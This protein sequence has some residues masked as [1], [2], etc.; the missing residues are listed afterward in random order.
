[1]TRLGI[2]GSN[3]RQGGGVTH[4]SSLLACVEPER[5]G[6]ERVVLWAGRDILEL[7]PDAP[8][9][10]KSHQADLDGG[11]R[12]RLS[13]QKFRFPGMADRSC[14]LVFAPG[15]LCNVRNTPFVTMCQNLLPFMWEELL[16]YNISYVTLRLILLRYGQLGAFRRAAGLIYLSDDSRRRLESGLVKPGNPASTVVY[17]GVDEGF[18]REPLPDLRLTGRDKDH[19]IRLLYVSII[20]MYKHPWN[21]AEAVA[22][23][24]REG[25]PVDLTLI[26]P[27]YAPALKKLRSTLDRLDPAGE[28]LHYRGPVPYADLPE[29][30]R[31]ADL[32]L[33]ASTC[34]TFGMILLEAMASGT[35]VLCSDRTAMPEILQDHGDYFDPESVGRIADALRSSIQNDERRN[36]LAAGAYLRAREFTWKRCADQTFRFLADVRKGAG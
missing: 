31:N 2:D 13:W 23:L 1:M 21:V 11:L 19:P 27:A 26:G 3:I 33:F 10:E 16:R 34:E 17:H 24:R 25:L 22:R 12:S 36:R 14:D 5:Y 29:V 6:F 4:L 8:W 35:P 15:G 32:F 9:L 30:Y 20:D 7:I 18:Y 28:F